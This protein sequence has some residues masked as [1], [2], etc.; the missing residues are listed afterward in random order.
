MAPLLLH[1]PDIPLVLRLP[2]LEVLR[3]GL[4]SSGLALAS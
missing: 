3:I 2:V 1:P 4:F